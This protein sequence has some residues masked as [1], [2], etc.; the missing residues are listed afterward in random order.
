[1]NM[2]GV[3]IIPT[4]IGAEIGGHAGDGNPVAKL[5]ASCCD[6]L[7]THPNV[8]NASDINEMTENTLYVEGSILDRF[9]EGT[10]ELTETKNNKIFTNHS[11]T[12]P[13][14]PKSISIKGIKAIKSVPKSSAIILIIGITPSR[15]LNN[16]F[17]AIE[18]N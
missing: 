2:I 6:K 7:I 13:S 14:T 10:I 12:G 1:M 4:G 8:V 3:L 18:I 15:I 5:I 11:I 17:K 9:L 16:G